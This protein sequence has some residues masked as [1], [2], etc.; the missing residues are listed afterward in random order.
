MGKATLC[1]YHGARYL[2]RRQSHHGFVAEASSTVA[3]ELMTAI[4]AP[5]STT[6]VITTSIM[7]AGSA[8]RRSSVRWGVARKI[9]AAW[10]V[11]LP[12]TM[13]LGGLI[14]FLISFVLA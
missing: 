14:A 1:N 12:A 5:V 4:G 10:F 6:Q 9:I 11:T 2:Y 13:A 7:G 3:I 8:R